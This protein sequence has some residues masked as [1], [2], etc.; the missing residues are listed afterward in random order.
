MKDATATCKLRLLVDPSI[1]V[2]NSIKVETRQFLCALLNTF[3]RTYEENEKNNEKIVSFNGTI[4]Y[5]IKG[6]SFN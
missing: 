1:L 4:S 3:Y 5:L 2:E 6:I